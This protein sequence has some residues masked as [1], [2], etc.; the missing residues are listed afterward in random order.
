MP[1]HKRCLIIFSKAPVA[2][3]VKT[4]LLPVLSAQQ[5]AHLYRLL[6]ERQ[7]RSAL[8]SGCADV[9]LW[10]S[11]DC[12]HEFFR[13]LQRR[14]AVTLHRQQGADLG[15]RMDHALHTVLQRADAAVLVGAD[16]PSLDGDDLCAAFARLEQG[17]DAVLTPT[18]DGGYALLG[19]RRVDT[20]LFEGIRW[21]SA[22]VLAQTRRVLGQ[23]GWNWSELE[24]RWDLDRPEDLQ[25]L[26]EAGLPS[27]LSAYARS[28]AV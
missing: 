28:I 25:R 10:C 16:I 24:E 15:Q 11:P 4:R 2:G 17:D 1:E 22:Q 23:L 21:G 3:Q 7:V 20:A 8:E 5:A 18:E 12:G 19:L 13:T 9:E 6:L 14:Y 27:E 26:R